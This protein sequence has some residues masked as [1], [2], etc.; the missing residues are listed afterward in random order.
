MEELLPA[1]TSAVE[2]Q[3]HTTLSNVES[4][5]VHESSTTPA[6][7]V[8]VSHESQNS[9]SDSLTDADQNRQ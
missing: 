2:T 1:V 7:V 5:S 6:S 9:E 4:S 8:E 3:S